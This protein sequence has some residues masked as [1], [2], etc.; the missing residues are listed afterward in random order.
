[1]AINTLLADT[2][3]INL[4][5][6]WP[7]TPCWPVQVEILPDEAPEN[8]KQS[9]RKTPFAKRIKEISLLPVIIEILLLRL[10]I[11]DDSCLFGVNLEKNK[12]RYQAREC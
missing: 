5:R 2:L 3:I 7:S 6:L 11:F 12:F 8:T 10:I 1:M 4:K 9:F